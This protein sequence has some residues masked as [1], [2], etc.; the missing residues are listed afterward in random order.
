MHGSVTLN[1]GSVYEKLSKIEIGTKKNIRSLTSVRLTFNN[2]RKEFQSP[3]FGVNDEAKVVNCE[4][5]IHK[6][7]ACHLRD[8]TCFLML[9]NDSRMAFGAQRTDAL[10]AVSQKEFTLRETQ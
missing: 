7:T 1:L 4:T 3:R 6:L 8:Q 2:G 5:V 10:Q 9:N